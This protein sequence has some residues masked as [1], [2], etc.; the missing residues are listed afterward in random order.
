ME[1]EMS[2]NYTADELNSMSQ[3]ELALIILSLQDQL[4][5]LNENFERLIE[6]VRIANQNQYG[7][8][9]E[10]L[11]VIDGQFSFFDEAEAYSDPDSE[12]PSVEETVKSYTR[13][14]VKGKRDSDLEGLPIEN[15][16]HSVSE[17]QLNAFY[18]A[19]NWKQLPTETFKR[20][21]YEPASWT[22]EVHS[23]EVY[24]GTGGD[25]QDEFLRGKRPKDLLRNSI[26][27]PSLGAAILNAKYVN[28]LPLYRISQEFER[29]GLTLSRQTMANWVIAFRKYFR[30][31]W[32][33]MKTHLLSL[34]VVQADETPTLV[35]H[36][37]RPTTSNSYM[38]VH[39]SGEFC[40]ETP[41][42]LYEY[43]QTR[44][45]D[46][47]KEF[48]KEYQGIL[49][50]DG[51]QQYH[52]LEKELSG[53]TNANCWTHARRDFAEACKAMDKKHVQAMR[54]STAHQ[55][56]E[57]IAGIFHEEEKLKELSADERLEQRTIKVK[58][59]V[60]AYFA[61]VRE[62]LSSEKLLP[63]GK[64]REGLNYS[65]NH[66]KYLKV[67]LTDG[68]VPID[69]S[70]SERSIRAFCLGKKNWV[71]INTIKGAEANA[72]AYSIS[73]S[74]K[75]NNLKPY[76]YFKHLLT[77]LPEHTDKEGNIPLDVLDSVMPWSKSLPEECY[78]CH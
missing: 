30:P 27:T 69:N 10:K 65:I 15:I 55:A 53:L 34:P 72:I 7:R 1:D 77:V 23:V 68:N 45:H 24:V 57:L 48:Y 26:V 64:T 31:L 66:E 70:A 59:L 12:E 32:N 78:K 16:A 41:I 33:R 2:R 62:Q 4:Q 38:W 54:M 5:N 40:R 52:L 20:L 44:H 14:K 56:L 21:R 43:Q 6:Q 75:A 35:I 76:M 9:S 39:R 17:D 36:D 11:D 63:K 50:T 28:A 47:P 58:P 49:E 71:L 46:H 42:I 25:H 3:K 73:E 51:L 13:K 22:V 37:G 29:N 18:G 60:E 67:F 61:W 19:G 74:A 8:R